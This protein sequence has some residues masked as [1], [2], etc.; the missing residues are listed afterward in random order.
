MRDKYMNIQKINELYEKRKNTANPIYYYQVIDQSDEILNYLE[1]SLYYF[2]ELNVWHIYFE[3]ENLDFVKEMDKYI[4]ANNDVSLE[5]QIINELYKRKYSISCAESCTGGMII[6]R[7]I[8][9]SG[10]SNVIN[11]SYVTYSNEAKIRIL[12]VNKE[13][14]DKY[15]VTSLEVADE[16]AKGV[17]KISNANVCLSVTGFAGSGTIKLDTDGLCYFGIMIN[18][19]LYHEK[20]QVSGNRNECRYAQSTYI[21]WKTLILLK[22]IRGE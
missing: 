18:N 17:K 12:G 15:T 9:V 22:N 1:N 13:T 5:K 2:K 10:A 7:L 8:G 6:S 14:I 3:E 20:I 4:I 21:L 16:M 19:K 11:E